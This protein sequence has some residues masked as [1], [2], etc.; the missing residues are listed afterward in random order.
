MKVKSTIRQKLKSQ[1]TTTEA[2]GEKVS[3]HD[4]YQ[5]LLNR[6][7]L[8]KEH[9]ESL[10]ARGLS[11][12]EIKQFGYKSFP[13][14]RKDI[15]QGLVDEFGH[16]SL[17]RSEVPGFYTNTIGGLE[18]AGRSGIAIPL[19][20][21][22]GK[23][24]SIKIRIDRPSNPATKYLLLSS[25][26]APDRKSGLVRYPSGAAAKAKIHYPLVRPKDCKTIRITEGELKADITSS[27]TDVYTISLP[28]ISV[29]R[30]ALDAIKIIKPDKILLA[31]DSDKGKGTNAGYDKQNKEDEQSEGVQ[32]EQFIVGKA[33]SSLYLSLKNEAANL[34]I[35]EIGIEDWPFEA[36]KGIDDVLVNGAT[37][38]IRVLS[39]EEADAFAQQMLGANL[40]DGWVYVVGVKRFYHIETLLE[41][42]KEQYGD[43][44]LHI[45]KGNPAANALR[46]PALTK[47]DSPIYMPNKPVIYEENNRKFFNTW[48]PGTLKPQQGDVGRF[49]EHCEYILP[50]KFERE[51][52]MDWLAYNIQNH[53]KKILWAVLLKGEPGTGKSYFGTLM[54]W[55]LGEQNVS[56]PTNEMIHEVYTAW[57]KS[58]QLIVIE[59]IM[60]RG[61]LELMN[62]LK[63][64]ITQPTTIVREMHKPAYE[65][66]NV[67]N[68]LM[69]TN[70]NDALLIDKEDRR[71][72]V[73]FSPAKPLKHEYYASL[74]DWTRENKS[75]ILHWFLE[76]DLS[77]FQPLAHAPMTKGKDELISE[78]MT[79]VQAWVTE[80]IEEGSWPFSG[81]LI[82]INHLVECAPKNMR[83][84]SR[85]NI[86]KALKAAGARKIESP[87]L[88]KNGNQ[89][90][91]WS[92]RRHEIWAGAERE[93]IA[94]E[95][96]RWSSANEPGGNPL[97]EARP[98]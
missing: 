75:A 97:M 29:W 20:D 59:E 6:L 90:R 34:G 93:T 48:R 73:L 81:D 82:G 61:R 92:I 84:A 78:G 67:F 36:G 38:K 33:V 28:G 13:T 57:V 63:P 51:I 70:H 24:H 10:V 30:Q 35:D 22:D 2:K 55:L 53:G 4:V 94:S 8:T 14:K 9:E 96:E 52:F 50:D 66:P 71:Y 85:Q 39:G 65:Q 3:H 7:E 41:L 37:D 83:N 47:V 46:N 76:R 42:D 72:C 77:Q 64:M 69:F 1:E 60:A 95:Y 54:R 56:C 89:V 16:D 58:C 25:N 11:P 91:L 27:L 80:G 21:V 74:W 18:L 44:Y 23:I 86:A 87:I 15:V 19:R 62:K 88:L 98:M 40:Q 17:I 5:S 31:F 12:Q 43:R 45:E 79:D 26:P 32:Q 68:I 49:L